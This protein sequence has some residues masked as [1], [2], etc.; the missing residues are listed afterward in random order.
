MKP[1]RAEWVAKSPQGAGKS[2][3]PALRRV[4][5]ITMFRRYCVALV[6]GAL[7]VMIASGS[8]AGAQSVPMPVPAPHSKAQAKLL[9]AATTPTAPTA[10]TAPTTA[11]KPSE[12]LAAKK[13][14]EATANAAAQA[15]PAIVGGGRNNTVRAA[16]GNLDAGQR[17]LVEKVNNYLSNL[18]TLVGN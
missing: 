13:L 4:G 11:P 5:R 17:A 10:P 8:P 18:N 16:T 1:G 6:G 12:I 3:P 7:S 14:A 2:S 15:P 9:A